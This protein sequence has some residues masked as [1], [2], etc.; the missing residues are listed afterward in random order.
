MDLSSV[1]AVKVVVAGSAAE[2]C[3]NISAR[4]RLNHEAIPAF[5]VGVPISIENTLISSRYAVTISQREL[6]ASLPANRSSHDGFQSVPQFSL[7]TSIS[8]LN[9]ASLPTR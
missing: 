6:V 5:A 2:N 9:R 4:R 7:R 8:A 1:I 3:V